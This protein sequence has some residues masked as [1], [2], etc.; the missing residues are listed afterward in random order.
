[1]DRFLTKDGL[2]ILDKDMTTHELRDMYFTI[3]A[4]IRRAFIHIEKDQL[5]NNQRE[6]L[7]FIKDHSSDD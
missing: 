4:M 5:N 1:M 6:L 2:P 3:K 7:N